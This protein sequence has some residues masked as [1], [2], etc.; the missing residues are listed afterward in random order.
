MCK[1]AVE[2]YPILSTQMSR[3][4]LAALCAYM[5]CTIPCVRRD[6]FFIAFVARLPLYSGGGLQVLLV[7]GGRFCILQYICRLRLLIYVCV[8]LRFSY[9]SFC[10]CTVRG[11]SII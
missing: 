6:T 2:S 7:D 5:V 1:T 8:L 9:L 11:R 3:L 10:V 4:F